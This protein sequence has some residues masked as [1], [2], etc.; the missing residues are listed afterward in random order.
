MKLRLGLIVTPFAI[1]AILLQA[2]WWV[3]GPD[4]HAAISAKRWGAFVQS[5]SGDAKLLNPILNAD[6]ASARIVDLVF[7][8][9]L[10]LDENLNLR[11]R[12]AH[13]WSIDEKARL[14]LI[15]DAPLAD[16]RTV[17][18]DELARSIETHLKALPALREHVLSVRLRPEE[19]AEK[20]LTIE[21][22]N[23]EPV[24]A[25]VQITV[26]PTLEIH[27]AKVFQDLEKE[28]AK[29]LGKDYGQQF[30]P[31]TSIRVQSPR[32]TGSALT[33]SDEQ[34]R[35]LLPWLTHRPRIRFHLRKGVRFHDGHE[36]DAG[37]VA[38]TY[39]A[40]MNPRNLSPRTSDFEPIERVEIVDAYTVDVIYKRLFAPAIK[41]WTM[42]LLPAHL[43]DERAREKELARAKVS[44]SAAK[45]FGMRQYGFNRH[46][47]GT[48]PFRFVK[49]HSDEQIHLTRNRGYWDGAPLYADFFYR[50]LPDPLTR[51]IE[52]RTGA[53]DIYMP[54]PHQSARYKD[55]E[56]YQA[57]SY[58]T[59]GYT[60]IG[61][62]QRR[63]PFDDVRVRRALGM[64]IDTAKIIRYVLYGEGE[65]AT[66]PYP[67]TTPW[68]DP[69][70]PGLKFDPEAARRLLAE[71]GWEPNSEGWLSKNGKLLEFNLI[72]N[73]GNAVRKAVLAIAQDAWRGIGV[74]VNT[75]LFEWAVFLEDFIN[76]GEFDAV[77]LGWRLGTDFDQFQIWHSSQTNRNQL[78]FVGY[79]SERA[80]HLLLRMRKEYDPAV[81]RQLAH[82]FHRVIARDQPYTFLFAPK[83]TAVLDRRVAMALEDGGHEPVRISK[84]GDIFIHMNRWQKVAHVQ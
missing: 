32:D 74:K 6:T 15:E 24:V 8:G 78:N 4:S 55:D 84:A 45:A 19:S 64:A 16:G 57:F 36:F 38:F 3:P 77:I 37:D 39:E 72:S 73:N 27:L 29:I 30:D 59:L 83:A 33:L 46:P 69:S 9:L 18:A 79:R 11:G 70:V 21:N 80:D 50:I 13:R 76:P 51:E 22:E 49:W 81:Q 20:E 47:V 58:A 60:Y 2:L 23:G 12:L 26:P 53:A 82:D 34:A 61:Y 43:L 42:P 66:G 56:Q 67:A 48:G 17:S 25:K 1:V 7:D 35:T 62:N 68:Y 41:A 14:I 40:I 71:A 65:K 31:R 10:G 5:S 44:G 54:L 28:L 52:F 63:A 75:Q